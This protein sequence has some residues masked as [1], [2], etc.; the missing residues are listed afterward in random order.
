[1]SAAVRVASRLL[2][3]RAGLHLS[4]GLQERL[5]A[6]VQRE[7][8]ARG[9]IPERYVA[10]LA[11]D[12]DSFQRL[13]DCVT[14]QETSFFR[15]PDQF[16]AL[17]RNLLPALQPPVTIWSA[18]CANGQEAYSLA[19]VLAGSGCS[20]WQV[21]ATDISSTAVD[22]TRAARY[23]TAELTG[24]P[25]PHRRWLRQA[26]EAWEVDPGLRQRLQVQRINLTER[27]PCEA[28]RCQ[29]VFCRNVLIYLA[30]AEVA[31]FMDRLGTWLAPGGAVFLG[32]SET[33]TAPTGRLRVEQ[34][35][36]AWVLRR[37]APTSGA[38]A[39]PAR[40]RP[41]ATP[42]RAEVAGA[43]AAG[44][45]EALAMVAAGEAA[46]ARGDLGSAVGDF[47]KAVYLDPDQPI[48]HFQL[49]LAL[50][51]G[52]DVRSARRAYAAALGALDRC[53]PETVA[54]GLEG[55]RPSELGAVLRDK[56]A[57]ARAPTGEPDR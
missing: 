16:A 44:T 42:V 4:R 17:E 57:K 28:G 46:A 37:P 20:D 6:C 29:V 54:T 7:A 2:A 36:D 23:T 8:Q 33:L 3:E 43:G 32:Y 51:A 14:I 24:L 21:L 47:R 5:A 52:G 11:A 49:G 39:A 38:G 55:W 10:G 31:A 45:P 1:M 18:G 27:F 12:P 15:H 13:L 22:R 40:R 26:G 35:G 9:E 34:L 48:A 53:D 50:E 56:L 41:Q 25:A 30:R 19:M